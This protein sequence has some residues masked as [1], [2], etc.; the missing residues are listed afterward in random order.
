MNIPGTVARCVCINACT[1]YCILHFYHEL[2]Q[3]YEKWLSTVYALCTLSPTECRYAQ[4]EKEAL[5]SHYFYACVHFQ[6]NLV[7]KSLDI[8]TDQLSFLSEFSILISH[9][10]GKY[11]ATADTLS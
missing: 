9:T 8:N 1:M 5:I 2:L 3:Y 4:I 6:E 10:P 11:L 7:G